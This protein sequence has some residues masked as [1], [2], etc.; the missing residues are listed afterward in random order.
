MKSRSVPFL[1]AGL[2]VS[3]IDATAF[4]Q[5]RDSVAL[6]PDITVSLDG[7]ADFVSIQAAIDSLPRTNLDRTVILL[8]DGIYRERFAVD[9]NRVT[10]RGQSRQ[11][12]LVCFDLAHEAYNQRQADYEPDP[13]RTIGRAVINITGNDVVIESMT[14]A[15]LNQE[16]G[17]HAFTVY[18]KGTRTVLLDCA[19]LSNGADTVSLWDNEAGMYYHANC[20]FMGSVDYVCPRGWCFISDSRFRQIGGSAGLWH[21]GSRE[22]DQKF[23]I[24]HSTIDGYPGF[25]LARRHHDAQFYFLDCSISANMSDRAIFRKTY[26]DDPSRDRPNRWGDRYYFHNTHREGDAGDPEWLHDNLGTAEG[27]PT[28][29]QVTAAWTFAGKWDP[30]STTPPKVVSVQ[31]DDDRLVVAFS[32]DVCVRDKVSLTLTGG[33]A[34][35]LEGSGGDRLVFRAFG[36]G[37]VQ[38]INGTIIAAQASR[39]PRVVSPGRAGSNKHQGKAPTS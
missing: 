13:D 10:L 32:E 22:K 27:S 34:T 21:D 11:G 31:R 15:N 7:K 17:P 3:A 1:I 25:I 30:E 26:P 6:K 20:F 19:L 35:Y 23:V 2:L 8:Q 37:E 29:E 12:V 24:R 5:P 28:P 18:G 14:V 16:V 33:R 36:G 39:H 4:P 38:S 9:R